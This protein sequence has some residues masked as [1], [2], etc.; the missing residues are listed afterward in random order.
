MKWT[1]E[2]NQLLFSLLHK[3]YKVGLTLNVQ[4]DVFN[5]NRVHQ[6]VGTLFISKCQKKCTL[7]DVI[8]HLSTKTLDIIKCSC[9]LS[10]SIEKND[11]RRVLYCDHCGIKLKIPCPR[12]N[13]AQYIRDLYVPNESGQPY[14]TY[15]INSLRS[16]V[17]EVY[18][19]PGK[20]QFEKKYIQDLYKKRFPMLHKIRTNSSI[21]QKIRV[22]WYL[23]ESEI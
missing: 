5:V 4:H 23:I 13:L 9:S 16:C 19:Q 8:R 3:Y 22:I 17:E 20:F 15:E 6:S 18:D 7:G 21:A 14:S 10:T 11:T 2:D 1:N 12:E